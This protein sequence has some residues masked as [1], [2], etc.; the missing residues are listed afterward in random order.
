MEPVKK[1]NTKFELDVEPKH[2]SIVK[3]IFE[4]VIPFQTVWAYGSR[5]ID[6][7]K[8]YSDLDIVVFGIDLKTLSDLEEAFEESDLPY[9][10]DIMK[11]EE[12]PDS[13]KENIQ[14]NYF[15]LQG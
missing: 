13:F 5:T 11:W 15:V 2:L 9:R 14:K 8:K 7:A 1:E 10:V 4:E 3:K 6:S 12:I